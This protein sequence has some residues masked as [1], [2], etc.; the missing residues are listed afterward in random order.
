[1]PLYLDSIYGLSILRRMIYSLLFPKK[2]KQYLSLIFRYFSKGIVMD[3]DAEK[4]KNFLEAI[5]IFSSK[6]GDDDIYKRILMEVLFE[7]LCGKEVK[8]YGNN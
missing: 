8:K 6:L 7:E 4:V 1:M 2:E 5:S 3:N